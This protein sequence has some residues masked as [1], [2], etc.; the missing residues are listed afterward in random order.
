LQIPAVC[1]RI[2][3]SFESGGVHAL[4]VLALAGWGSGQGILVFPA[5]LLRCQPSIELRFVDHA[6]LSDFHKEMSYSFYFPAIVQIAQ[7]IQWKCGIFLGKLLECKEIR[8]V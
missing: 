7:T 3:K 1:A 6:E 5:F 8:R 2:K 4:S